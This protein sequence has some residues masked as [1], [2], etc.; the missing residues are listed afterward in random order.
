MI[1][2]E[3]LPVPSIRGGAIQ[4]LIDGIIPYLKKNNDITVFS[5]EDEELPCFEHANR[6]R[7]IRV[8]RD[9]YPYEVAKVLS[10]KRIPN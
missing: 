10:K 3:K 2:T 8:K 4:I 1:C 9:D 5:I 6:L 7:Y